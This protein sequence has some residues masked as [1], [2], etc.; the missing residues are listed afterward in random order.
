MTDELRELAERYRDDILVL[1][2]ARART[3]YVALFDGELYT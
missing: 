1:D 2:D 3:V